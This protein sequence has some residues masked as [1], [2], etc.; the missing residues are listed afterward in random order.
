MDLG[1]RIL[2]FLIAEDEAANALLGPDRITPAAGNPHYTVSQR[3]AFMRQKGSKVGCIG[4]K[5]LTFLF[6]PFYWNVKDYDHC[7][8][9]IEGF[10]DNLPSDG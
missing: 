3:L 5:V 1:K 6:K 8:A 7:A 10:A 2:A 4:C 9:A